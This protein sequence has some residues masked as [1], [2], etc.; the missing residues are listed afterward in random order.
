MVGAELHLEALGGAFERRVHHARVVD[1]Q[2]QTGVRHREPVGEAAHAGERREV[3]QAD[4]RAT[5]RAPAS[6]IVSPRPRRGAP[7]RAPASTT[8]APAAASARAVSS[9]RPVDAPVT[10][11]TFPC[12]STPC[13]H[14]VGRRLEAHDGLPLRPVGPLLR[15]SPRPHRVAALEERHHALARVV[16]P[17]Q[18]VVELGLQPADL[19]AVELEALP[20]QPL[21]ERDRHRRGVHR[22]VVRDLPRRRQHL[23]VGEAATRHPEPLHLVPVERAPGEQ[24]L[25]RVGHAHDARQRPVHEGVA[26]HPAPHLHDAVLGVGRHEPQVALDRQ[27]EPERRWR[28]R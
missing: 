16:A 21:A 15:H 19:G 2:V 14:L 12:R 7:R 18:V 3:E 25:G 9:P 27:R 10:T 26:H 28:A 17:H 6:R 11:A 8:F 20:Q 13:E 5:R 22:D 23:V 24:D 1:Q 4:P